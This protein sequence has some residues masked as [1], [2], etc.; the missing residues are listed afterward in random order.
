MPHKIQ[1]FTLLFLMLG[2]FK[3]IGPFS[4]L[5]QGADPK[6][7]RQISVRAMMFSSIALLL[8]AFLGQR[9]ISNFD[10]PLPILAIS[11]GLILFLVALLTIIKQF[12]TTP[13]IEERNFVP[14]LNMALSP[15]A[16]PTI[17][18]PYGIAAIIVF[19]ALSP[20]LG[21]KLYVGVIVLAI[22]A[23]NLILM[24]IT[25]YIYKPLTVIL[26]LLGAILGIVQVAVGLMI[27]YNQF[28]ILLKM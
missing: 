3:I 12:G 8:A 4:K 27:I 6:L 9:I 18:T 1:I 2:P 7:V 22:M 26:S 24:L 19:L 20:D 17:V 13:T 16:F 14:T 23:L 10:I 5:T 28:R 21:S 25:R 15:L 11:G